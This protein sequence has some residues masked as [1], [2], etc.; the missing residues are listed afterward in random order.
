[1]STLW[2]AMC[3]QNNYTNSDLVRGGCLYAMAGTDPVSQLISATSGPP[4]VS[5]S[6]DQRTMD[7]TMDRTISTGKTLTR[8]I[9]RT[10]SK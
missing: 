1:M 6:D 10:E 5:R 3:V 8:Q 7:R 9:R 4:N 2:A